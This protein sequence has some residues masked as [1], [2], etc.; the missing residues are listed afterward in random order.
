MIKFSRFAA[1]ALLPLAAAFAQQTLTLTDGT[2]I[3]GRLVSSTANTIVFREMDG[4]LRRFNINQ[5]QDLSFGGNGA[6]NGA[7]NNGS[8]N[9]GDYNNDG[10]RV[11][12]PPPP[13]VYN[14][15]RRVDTAPP[16]GYQQPAYNSNP[17]SGYQTNNQIYTRQTEQN[18]TTWNTLPSGTQIAVRTNEQINSRN[19]G[20][21]RTYT[22]SI[23]QD[24]LDANGNLI[25][26]QGSDAQLVVRNVGDNTVALDLHSISVNGVMYQVDSEDIRQTGSGRDGLGKNKRTGEFVGGGAL[27][28]TLL[29]AIA[30]GGKGA[31]I[32]AV[33]GGAAGAGTEVLTKGDSVRVPAE[34][35]L[36]FRLDSPLQ[37]NQ[38]R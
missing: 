37:L 10:R 25:V 28:G 38:P 3:Q 5:L 14:D 27:L 18:Y 26:P 6:Y 32:G 33:A 16:R 2:Q 36:T 34:T 4:D 21:G 31:L 30:G 22:A 19:A 7:E 20:N 1:V 8:F 11:D 23:A 13:A 24:I 15:G 17:N 9:R 35:V 29:G 12:G